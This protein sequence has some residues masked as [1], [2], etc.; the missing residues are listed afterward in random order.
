MFLVLVRCERCLETKAGKGE[1]SLGEGEQQPSARSLFAEN[2][3]STISSPGHPMFR[4]AASPKRQ[5]EQSCLPL[6]ANLSTSFFVM[7]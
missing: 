3:R 1:A 6:S 5:I 7:A 4:D 2:I